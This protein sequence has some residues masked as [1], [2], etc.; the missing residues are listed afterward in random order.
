[1]EVTFP[2]SYITILLLFRSLMQKALYIEDIAQARLTGKLSSP[3]DSILPDSVHYAW[4]VRMKWIVDKVRI[5][6]I[7]PLTIVLSVS[8]PYSLP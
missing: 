4:F 2:R 1:M 7:L 6:F 8:L 3:I 5:I